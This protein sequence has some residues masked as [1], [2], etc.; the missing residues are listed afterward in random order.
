MLIYIAIA[1]F[2]LLTLFA[3]LFVGEIFGDHDFGHEVAA[4]HLDSDHGG[5]SIFSVRIMGAFLTAFGVGGVIG[6]YYR[7]SHP[8]ASGIGVVTGVVMASIVY[9]FAKILYSQQASSEISMQGLV[10]G[11]AEVSVAIPAG[12]VGQVS[13]SSAGARSEHIARSIDGRSL[14][15]GTVVVIKRVGG[16]SLV[17]A[18]VDAPASGGSS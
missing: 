17:V 1:G 12:G 15:R 9:Q 8:A 18:A 6:R 10:G 4:G 11:T 3:M 13:V 7:F 14:S 2:G 16:D 5:P